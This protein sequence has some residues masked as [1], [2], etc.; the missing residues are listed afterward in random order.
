MKLTANKCQ[1]TMPELVHTCFPHSPKRKFSSYQT[2][3][4]F[5]ATSEPRKG[6][7]DQKFWI[8]ISYIRL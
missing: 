6:R 5:H 4:H 8:D 2:A 7:Q 3:Q 1:T